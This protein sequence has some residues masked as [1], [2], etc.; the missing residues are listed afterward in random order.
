MRAFCVREFSE[1]KVERERGFRALILV[2]MILQQRIAATAS[3]RIVERLTEIVPTEKPLETTA[4][5]AVPIVISRDSERF[6]TSGE[7]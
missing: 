3:G 2:E 1:G 4:R 5:C 7:H 6:E